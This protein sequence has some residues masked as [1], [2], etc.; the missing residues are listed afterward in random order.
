MSLLA[1]YRQQLIDEAAGRSQR[2]ARV[3]GY[4]KA[5]W[6]FVT[7]VGV[8]LA[9]WLILSEVRSSDPTTGGWG[10]FLAPVLAIIV[11]IAGYVPYAIGQLFLSVRPQIDG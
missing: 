7:A 6:L 11:S 1:S 8:V 10:F 2:F 9:A 5:L 3:L 4:L